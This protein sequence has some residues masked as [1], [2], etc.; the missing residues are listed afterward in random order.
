MNVIAGASTTRTTTETLVADSGTNGGLQF[1]NVF[2]YQNFNANA[3]VNFR[4]NSYEVRGSSIFA[5]ATIGFNDNIFVDLTA[6]ND[7]TS[8]LPE[9]NNSF[10]YPSVGVT[11][12]LSDLFD[13]GE[14][15]SYAKARVSYAEVGNG[16]GPDLISPNNSIIF[17]GWRNTILFSKQLNHLLT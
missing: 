10:F 1:A 15:V 4:Q 14:K 7:W 8:T 13:L 3:S 2:A 16:F 5:S 6:R 12:I 9:A 11:G 17:G